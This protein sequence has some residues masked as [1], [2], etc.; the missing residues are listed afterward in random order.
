[1]TIKNFARTASLLA[2]GSLEMSGQFP[3]HRDAVVLQ[4]W[5]S[6]L[7]WQQALPRQEANAPASAPGTATLPTPATSLVFVALPPCRVVDT[8]TSGGF[9]GAFGPPTV[10][11]GTSRTF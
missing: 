9:S 10:G 4:H 11:G 1:M 8:R 3:R 5:Q 2:I 7:Y 6:P